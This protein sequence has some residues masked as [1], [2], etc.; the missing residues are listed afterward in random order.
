[1]PMPS[2]TKTMIMCVGLCATAAARS[3]LSLCVTCGDGGEVAGATLICDMVFSRR[4]VV[5]C[6]IF[7]MNAFDCTCSAFYI[8]LKTAHIGSHG[9]MIKSSTMPERTAHNI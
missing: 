4:G 6:S 5:W 2:H 9:G 7:I 3:S 8:H 1:M